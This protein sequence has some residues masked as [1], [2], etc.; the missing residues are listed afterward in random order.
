MRSGRAGPSLCSN[1][2]HLGILDG[3]GPGRGATAGCPGAARAPAR[4]RSGRARAMFWSSWC[5]CLATPRRD[6]GSGHGGAG[7][8]DVLVLV[9]PR[10]RNVAPGMP[11]RGTEGPGRAMFWSWWCHLVA[12]PPPGGTLGARIVLFGLN[13]RPN[14]PTP[15][16]RTAPAPELP[17]RARPGWPKGS[18]GAPDATSAR[19]GP[20]R[21]KHGTFR[22][23]RRHF[24]PHGPATPARGRNGAL[25]SG[26][27]LG[28]HGVGPLHSPERGGSTAVKRRH[29]RS[30]P[31]TPTRRRL[32]A[33]ATRRYIANAPTTRGVTTCQYAAPFA[34]PPNPRKLRADLVTTEA[35]SRASRLES[36]RGW[37]KTPRN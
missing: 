3:R 29:P 21:R 23:P 35:R 8:C 27:R 19:H 15:A 7:A 16:R 26:P 12:T 20:G 2:R 17:T 28:A 4:P 6:A 34:I 22:R 10:S 31:T 11:A 25:G 32:T 36:K 33:G 30:Q 24:R 14:P 9:V 1:A 18:F 37:P 13:R 5:Q